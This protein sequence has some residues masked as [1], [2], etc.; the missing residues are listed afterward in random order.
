MED[1]ERSDGTAPNTTVKDLYALY[2]DSLLPVISTD[3]AG[4]EG[5]GSAFHVGGGSFVTARHVVEGMASCQVEIDWRRLRKADQ[6]LARAMKGNA[7]LLAIEPRMHPD[8]DIDVA[9][10]SIPMLACL[11]A[12]PLGGHLDDWIADHDVVLNEVLV[13]GFPPIPLS[14][15]NVLVAT[16]A[17]INAVVDLINVRHVHFIASAMAR[18]GFSGGVALSEWG[19]ALGLVT[20]SL[21]RNEAPAELGYLT[22]LTVEPILQCL[23]AHELM[24]LDLALDWDG[25]FTSE[26]EYFGVPDERRAHSWV[27]TDRD[28]HRARIKFGTPDDELEI[29]L[30]EAM[31]AYGT[32]S[33]GQ[34]EEGSAEIIWT[35]SGAYGESQAPIEH[36]RLTLRQLFI[37][38]GYLPVD[39]PVHIHHSLKAEDMPWTDFDEPL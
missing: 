37:A 10:F 11:P 26:T 9:V 29:S 3:E 5:I 30:N 31:S 20:S 28:G 12:V 24:P 6:S 19:F 7:T 36:A 27:E 2:R 15:E 14:K 23:A 17:Q 34:Q 38:R 8:P 25:L 13:L 1:C 39:Q 4:D 33:R 32:F 22:I 21:L 16:R 35:F 18:G